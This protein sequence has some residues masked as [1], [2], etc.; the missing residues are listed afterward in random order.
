MFSLPTDAASQRYA[1]AAN[2]FR[3]PWQLTVFT[4]TANP[5]TE[6]PY[7][8]KVFQ[9]LILFFL[10]SLQLLLQHFLLLCE[11]QDLFLQQLKFI[12]FFW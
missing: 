7:Q 5:V 2:V 4:K 11:R 10:Q 6:N 9:T 12:A 8:L 3:Q 1:P